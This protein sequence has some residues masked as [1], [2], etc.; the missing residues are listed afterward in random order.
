MTQIQKIVSTCS[1]S[2]YQ[3]AADTK[4]P[5]TTVQRMVTGEVI[6]PNRG[7]QIVIDQWIENW[8]KAAKKMLQ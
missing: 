8:K 1:V 5:R 3:I 4:L 2:V 7:T 6:E